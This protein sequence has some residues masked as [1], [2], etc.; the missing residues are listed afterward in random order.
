MW[1]KVDSATSYTLQVEYGSS[2]DFAS[3]DDF[4]VLGTFKTTETSHIFYGIG[5]QVHRFKVIAK[6]ND[7]ILAETAW[8]YILTTN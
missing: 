3:A 1:N 5:Y 8:H 7:V 4:K 6:Q 2:R